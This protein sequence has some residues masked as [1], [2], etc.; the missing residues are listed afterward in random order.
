MFLQE[1]KEQI[2]INGMKLRKNSKALLLER[3]SARVNNAE[4]DGTIILIQK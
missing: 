2:A 3:H 4:S 1:K